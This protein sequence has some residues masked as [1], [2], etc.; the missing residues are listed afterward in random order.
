M[1]LSICSDQS[2][3]AEVSMDMN[4]YLVSI[5][6]I[7][8]F[9]TSL[10]TAEVAEMLFLFK[11]FQTTEIYSTQSCQV[12]YSKEHLHCTISYRSECRNILASSE[13]IAGDLEAAEKSLLGPVAVGLGCFQGSGYHRCLKLCCTAL[14][15]ADSLGMADI[16]NK[17]ILFYFF[18]HFKHT[19]RDS[20]STASVCGQLSQNSCPSLKDVKLIITKK[21]GEKRE[22]K[23]STTN[24]HHPPLRYPHVSSFFI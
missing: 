2:S 22:K 3:Y 9:L 8:E 15:Y 18:I 21:Q 4:L 11:K 6:E 23:K 12:S 16:F 20:K 17:Q 10:D 24:K 14:T 5:C 7:R 1:I 19:Q 13:K